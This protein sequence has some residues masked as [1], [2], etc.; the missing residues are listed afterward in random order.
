MYLM[1]SE[2]KTYANVVDQHLVK[3]DGSEGALDDVCDG[4]CGHDCK[5]I[6]RKLQPAN[7]K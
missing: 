5:I 7:I 2:C 3:A 4:C 6:K 1:L